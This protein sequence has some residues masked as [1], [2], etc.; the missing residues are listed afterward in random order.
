MVATFFARIA[1][2]LSLLLQPCAYEKLYKCMHPAGKELWDLRLLDNVGWD[3]GTHVSSMKPCAMLA[4]R[5]LF[6]SVKTGKNAG[7]GAK[8]GADG[9]TFLF[10]EL[11]SCVLVHNQCNGRAF[12]DGLRNENAK[13]RK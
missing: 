11:F 10:S 13:V 8:L 3:H 12:M 4:Q 1:K 9:K 6:R 2:V 5:G 7:K